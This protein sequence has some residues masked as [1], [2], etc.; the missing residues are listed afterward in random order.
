MTIDHTQQFYIDGEWVDPAGSDTL[1]VINPATEKPIATI[2][3][4]SAA[5][6]DRAVTAARKVFDSYAATTRE[7]RIDL[8]KRIVE[9]YKRRIGDVAEAVTEEMGAPAWLAS[10]AQRDSGTSSPPSPR[11]RTSPSRSR[12]APRRSSTSPSACAP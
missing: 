11:S 5:D 1:E 2:A 12:S 10:A 4:G 8:L 7:E 9:V 3:M 6:V